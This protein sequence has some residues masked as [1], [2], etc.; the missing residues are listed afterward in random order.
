MRATFI[1]GYKNKCFKCSRNFTN[2]GKFQQQLLFF[3]IL[4]GTLILFHRNCKPYILN[5]MNEM[6]SY[7]YVHLLQRNVK[8]GDFKNPFNVNHKRKKFFCFPIKISSVGLVSMPLFS[9]PRRQRQIDLCDFQAI[10]INPPSS[11][12]PHAQHI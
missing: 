1:C 4:L 2:L 3:G 8:T 10:Q 6:K 7:T 11:R 5:M 9:C 12:P